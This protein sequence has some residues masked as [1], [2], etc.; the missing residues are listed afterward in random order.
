M[1]EKVELSKEKRIKKE[2]AKLKRAFKDLDKNKKI[3]AESRM[4]RAAFLTVCLE[5]LEEIINQEGYEDEY[6]NGE[7]QKG[8]TQSN[9]VKTHIAM[10]RNLTVIMKQLDDLVPPEKKEK[11]KLALLRD[12]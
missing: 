6:Q 8:T 5:D 11:S 1:T 10:T 3:N 9:A 7:N 4:E 2:L 12:E